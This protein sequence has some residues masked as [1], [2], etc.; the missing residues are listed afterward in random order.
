MYNKTLT[1]VEIIVFCTKYQQQI[2]YLIII[3][4]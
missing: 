3:V 1:V 2:V 4:N